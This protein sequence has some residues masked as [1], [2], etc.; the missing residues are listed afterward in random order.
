MPLFI[1]P[2]F[3]SVWANTGVKLT[4]DASKITQGW[5]VEIPPYEFDNWI[6]NRQDA[7]LAHLNQ[8]GIPM[9]DQ[10]V[11]Y[12]AGKSYVQ[13]PNTGT[14]FRA[15][16]TNTN[17]NP[18]LDIQN[19][20]AVAF[21]AQVDALLKAQNLADVPDK[22]AA[23][24]N[25]GIATTEFY[26]NR[27]LI[28]SQNLA[29]LPNKASARNSLSVYARDEVYSRA[30][31]E[32]LIPAGEF[33]YFFTV[34]TI[35]WLHCNGAAVSR[36]TYVKLFAVIGTTFGAGNGT[37][38]FNLPDLRGE[39]IRGL[40][41]GRGIDPGRTLGSLQLSQN[42]SHNH[43]VQDPGHN[44]QFTID[45]DRSG[46]SGNAVLGD[47]PFYGQTTFNTTTSGTGVS[48]LPSGGNESRPRNLAFFPC[49]S[50]GLLS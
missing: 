13:G 15:L 27:Y 49:I 29:D 10:T 23:R 14:V 18:E 47:E 21:V 24:A 12:Q 46:G 9:W 26:D 31:V 48:I 7:L 43:T 22:A 6:Q 11:E 38:T 2:Q 42:A 30:E 33:S 45:R 41:S 36:T 20:W 28:K 50:T 32:S 34:P 19:N 8:L 5:I 16:T 25:L 3:N 39:F 37:T 35:G 40:D 1:K 4:P 44:H 17:I